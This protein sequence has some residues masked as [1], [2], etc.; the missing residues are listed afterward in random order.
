MVARFRETIPTEVH[1]VIRDLEKFRILTKIT[2]LSFFRKLD[3]LGVSQS[4]KALCNRREMS[5]WQL[6][7]HCY[8]MQNRV[9]RDEMG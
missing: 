4:G 2:I 7:R 5:G 3:F 1:F 8:F 9:L 6:V